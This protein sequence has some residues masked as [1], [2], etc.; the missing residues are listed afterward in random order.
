MAFRRQN[1]V[2]WAIRMPAKGDAL[3]R[4]SRYGNR[5]WLPGRYRECDHDR[6]AYRVDV[7]RLHRASIT[8]GPTNTSRR[9]A[10]P[11]GR[12]FHIT[13]AYQDLG[14]RDVTTDRHWVTSPLDTPSPHTTG[15]AGFR[16][17][18]YALYTD[19]GV[20]ALC[21]FPGP[22]NHYRSWIFSCVLALRVA[23]MIVYM[24]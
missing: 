14:G 4:T 19:R 1:R 21:T 3:G 2:G 23:T 13:N 17:P 16:T 7:H 15:I 8:D 12:S 9:L 22:E 18:G 11:E 24:L 5:N 20:I 6:G 10:S